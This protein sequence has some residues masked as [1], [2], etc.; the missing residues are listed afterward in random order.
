VKS[1]IR[2]TAVLL[3]VFALC[4]GVVS[5]GVVTAQTTEKAAEKTEQKAEKTDDK[6]CADHGQATEAE[7]A[8]SVPELADLHEVV[9]PLW[10]TAYPGKDYAMIKELIPQARELT[11]KLDKAVLPGILRDKQA[12]WDK[13]KLELQHS[14]QALDT[15]AKANNEEEMLKQTELFHANY[16]KLV[17]TIRPLTKELDAFHQ[18][19][20][21]LYHYYGPQ[22]DLPQIQTAAAAMG[23]KVEAL[24]T[25]KLPKRLA[26]KQGDFDAAVVELDGAVK[27][28]AETAKTDN[29]EKV[30]AAVETVHSGYVK[31]EHMFD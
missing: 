19:L 5:L 24:K 8:A 15:A 22:Y 20:Y 13:G 25:S 12:A 28:L 10:H 3:A 21:K 29:K 16:E 1:S 26:E 30:L 7:L 6:A 27:A 11:D 23:P 31:I 17:R 14:L 18:E 9:Y 2:N 4:L